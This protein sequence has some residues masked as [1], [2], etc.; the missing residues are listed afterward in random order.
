ML[1]IG[2]VLFDVLGGRSS[3]EQ[4]RSDENLYTLFSL[5]GVLILAV[6]LVGISVS[7]QEWL[8]DL[9][10]TIRGQQRTAADQPT[11]I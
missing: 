2:W 6:G 9:I 3:Q 11:V 8:K 5:V 10:R 4:Y 7:I 1:P